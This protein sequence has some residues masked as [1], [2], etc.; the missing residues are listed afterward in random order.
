MVLLNAAGEV[1]EGP[2]FNI[3][4]VSNGHLLTPAT[5]VLH[6]ITRDTVM[7]LASERGIITEVT[8]FGA[9]RL[10]SADEIFITNTAGGVMPVTRL[11]G[12]LVGDG[13]PGIITLSLRQAYW[14]AHC[15][16]RWATPLYA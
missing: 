8:M 15:D 4:A 7:T 5:G 14:D 10:S 11:D 1:T 16:P 6:G 12:Q 2:G 13:R 9:E 3:F